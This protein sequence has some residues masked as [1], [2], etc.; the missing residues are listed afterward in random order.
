MPPTDSRDA[1]IAALE[2]QRKDTAFVHS[3]ALNAAGGREK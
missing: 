1:R 2:Q 3:E